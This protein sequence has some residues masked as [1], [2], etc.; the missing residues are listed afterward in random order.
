MAC[1]I[2][3]LPGDKIRVKGR[4]GYK[5]GGNGTVV[6]YM[7]D[8][9]ASAV[10]VITGEAVSPPPPLKSTREPLMRGGDTRRS[11]RTCG[12]WAHGA[13]VDAQD[14]ATRRGG[15]CERLDGGLISWRPDEAPSIR[16]L[17]LS[18]KP[19]VTRRTGGLG[20]GHFHLTGHETYC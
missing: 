13:Q 4:E 15:R 3:V 17:Y 16:Y 6:V 7:S 14:A 20:P 19:R 10:G 18:R 5:E 8:R 2:V 9:E 11:S 1:N 12:T